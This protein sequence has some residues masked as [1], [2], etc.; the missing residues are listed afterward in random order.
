MY[1][2]WSILLC[3]VSKCIRNFFYSTFFLAWFN[4]TWSCVVPN[5]R[6]NCK[7][8]NWKIVIFHFWFNFK[9]P[10]YL[11]KILYFYWD[12]KLLSKVKKKFVRLRLP[13]RQIRFSPL[14]Y[15]TLS[16]CI[17]QISHQKKKIFLILFFVFQ[18]L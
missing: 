14:S 7:C 4:F 10:K 15:A 6:N 11:R 5:Q 9:Y 1:F 18:S 17:L 16:L 3:V 13:T 2:I 12:G 8:K